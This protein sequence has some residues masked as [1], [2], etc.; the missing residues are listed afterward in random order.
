MQPES[1]PIPD[2]H[3]PINEY[4]EDLWGYKDYSYVSEEKGRKIQ[5]TDPPLSTLV[6][7]GRFCCVRF[8]ECKDSKRKLA[9][10]WRVE[11]WKIDVQKLER[12]REAME[13][14]N[15]EWNYQNDKIVELKTRMM[16][17]FGYTEEDVKT[18]IEKL[19]RTGNKNAAKMFGVEL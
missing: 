12:D 18:F 10:V 1:N 5:K 9:Q 7:H 11:A 15:A 6:E 16:N 8:F 4:L 19:V 14:R 13:K 3:L 2:F 17:D